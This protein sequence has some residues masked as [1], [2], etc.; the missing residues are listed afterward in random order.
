[1][2]KIICL[3]VMTLL[4]GVNSIEGSILVLSAAGQQQTINGVIFATPNPSVGNIPSGTGSFL[5][6]KDTH[7][8]TESGFN[9]TYTPWSSLNPIPDDMTDAY[10]LPTDNIPL[11]EVG[12]SWY[13]EFAL[14][15]QEAGNP[16]YLNLN[17]LKLGG[18]SDPSVQDFASL[19]PF[20]IIDID[21][22]TDTIELTDIWGGTNIDMLMYVPSTNGV[23]ASDYVVMYN[24]FA[25]A[26]DGPNEWAV[27]EGT[28]VIPEPTT[29]I[30]W[31][32]LGALAVTFAWWRRR[33]AV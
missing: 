11:V 2:K 1:M 31:S 32:L 4:W 10:A 19:T 30:I 13:R 15:I 16:K 5:R 28:T 18:T 3:T 9:T 12:G 6:F 14:S 20:T 23:F 21:S 25:N 26:D 22:N 17:V 24:V 33:E 29:L 7:G 8:G 27:R